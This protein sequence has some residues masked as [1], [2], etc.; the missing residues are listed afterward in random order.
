MRQL[1]SSIKSL[2]D[3]DV[4]NYAS[5][6]WAARGSSVNELVMNMTRDGLRF[7]PASQGTEPAYM[8]VHSAFVAFDQALPDPVRAYPTAQQLRSQ[9]PQPR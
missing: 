5:G 3:S 8:A 6:K 1:E 7:A 9:P 2:S 4:A